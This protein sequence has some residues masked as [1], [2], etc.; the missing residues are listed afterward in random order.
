MALSS[1]VKIAS[2]AG[3]YTL[4]DGTATP[5]THTVR[6]DSADLSISGIQQALKETKAYQTRGKFV[7][8][9]KG[10]RSAVTFSFSCMQ[11]DLSEASSGTTLD[12]IFGKGASSARVTT[13]R[14]GGDVVTL[15][16][17]VSFEGTSYGDGAD[18]TMKFEDCEFSIDVSEGDPNTIKFNAT[19]YG[20]ISING[21]K[22]FDVN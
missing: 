15:D 9:R 14:I 4:A 13:G 6:F 5:L 20:D 17:T 7:S 11:S 1:V 16:F 8:L 10:A 22:W 3:S 19:C 2:D 18:Q 12:F 21:T